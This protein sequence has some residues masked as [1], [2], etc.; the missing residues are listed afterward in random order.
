MDHWNYTLS[1]KQE[2]LPISLTPDFLYT[3]YIQWNMAASGKEKYAQE[4]L[5]SAGWISSNVWLKN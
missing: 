3:R 4:I 2:A 1:T 5:Q